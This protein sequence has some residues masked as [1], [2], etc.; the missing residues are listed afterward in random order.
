M[1]PKVP[2]S[3]S[4]A[5]VLLRFFRKNEIETIFCVPG[6]QIEALLVAFASEPDIRIVLAAHEQGAVAM[7]DGYSRL[8]GKPGVVFTINGPGIL[9]AVT[10]ANTARHDNSPI[11]IISGDAPTSVRGN[12][13][14]QE[15]NREISDTLSIMRHACGWAIEIYNVETL[16]QA[17][18]R[19]GELARV[20]P[21]PLYMNIPTDIMLASP[22]GCPGDIDEPV[23]KANHSLP[24]GPLKIGNVVMLVSR[25]AASDSTIERS[26]AMAHRYRIPVAV[27]VSAKSWLD[28]IDPALRLGL[29]GY[30]GHERAICALLDQSTATILAIGLLWNER[31][32]LAWRLE[33]GKTIALDCSLP[34][35]C[36]FKAIG[37]ASVEELDR[38]DSVWSA[39][40]TASMA[41]REAV[42]L[43]W[44]RLPLSPSPGRVGPSPGLSSAEIMKA[45]NSALDIEGVLFVDS[46]D[47]RISAT[48]YFE[49]G[50]R[51]RFITAAR[52]G[53]MGWALGAAIGASFA[54]SGAPWVITGD[55]CMLMSGNEIAVAARYGR[56]V[57]VLVFDN[58]AYA[59]VALRLKNKPSLVMESIAFLPKIDWALYG[60]SLGVDSWC[61][62]SQE[63]LEI[64]I[65]KA[66]E[67]PRPALIVAKIPM[68]D[69]AYPDAIVSCSSEGWIR[70]HM[71][72]RSI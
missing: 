22:H 61:V 1:Q 17:L 69:P 32:T 36:M 62:H 10:M 64:A 53:P 5:A 38:L 56:P 63:E 9:N 25:D 72:E 49:A 39:E 47:H 30:A 18:D 67:S 41:E 59:R 28:R 20:E 29:Y 48:V 54:R 3:N 15:S 37:S 27:S 42:R 35:N 43:Q 11:L 51:R 34:S 7:A 2:A 52:T 66:S 44:M 21:R 50:H 13:A 57:K 60:K 45:L 8:G 4:I 12:W 19:F 23:I 70:S 68:E 46:G 55:G 33:S 65:L 6:A 14:F 71:A 24:I 58:G 26:I 31:N 16:Q 40:L